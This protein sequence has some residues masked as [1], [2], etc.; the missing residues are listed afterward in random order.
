MNILEQAY[1]S[2]YDQVPYQTSV[3]YN[4]KFSDFNAN[5]R[6]R[7]NHLELRMSKKWKTINTEI[8]MGLAQSL[9]LSLFKEKRTTLNVDLYNNFLKSLHLTIPKTKID[10]ILAESF[11]R[12]N[13]NCLNDLLEMPNLIWGHKSVR[14]LGSYNYKTDTITISSIFIQ[15]PQLL[16]YIMYH[17]LLH[18]K[19]KFSTKNNRNC[20]HDARFKKAEKAFPGSELMESLIKKLTRK[21]RRKTLFS[22][23]F[24]W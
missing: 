1:A 13:K 17:E 18:K 5:L 8:V 6:L 11:H 12:V 21:T 20:F 9:I 10:P 19:F 22:G 7:L 15:E 14:K 3:K 23:F 16:D 4:G 24:P 2:L